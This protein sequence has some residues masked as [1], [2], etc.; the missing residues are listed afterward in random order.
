[1]FDKSK[2]VKLASVIIQSSKL[3]IIPPR[4]MQPKQQNT[5][6]ALEEAIFA[7]SD[8]SILVFRIIY[9]KCYNANFDNLIYSDNKRINVLSSTNNLNPIVS[10]TLFSNS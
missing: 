10:L 6:A 8:L 9:L 3:S 1:M 4:W 2:L 7:L 5:V